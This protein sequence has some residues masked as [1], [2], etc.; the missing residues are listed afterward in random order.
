[1]MTL[2]PEGFGYDSGAANASASSTSF[3]SVWGLTGS[4]TL[5]WRGWY[6]GNPAATNNVVMW[7][8]IQSSAAIPNSCYSLG[9]DTSNTGAMAFFYSTGTTANTLAGSAFISPYGSMTVAATFVVGGA[10]NLYV[11]VADS[12][13]PP[14]YP[15]ILDAGTWSGAAP[16][17]PSTVQPCMGIDPVS[18]AADF[19]QSV[20]TSAYIYNRALSLDEVMWLNAEPFSFLRPA[21]RRLRSPPASAGSPYRR[22]NRTYLIR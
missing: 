4:G 2:G 6:Y 22:W 10:I 3:P 17:Y 18:D 7:G 14:K 20:T 1:M 15:L 8:N 19:S 16:S 13:H 12:S 5:F 21:V 11:W 9:I